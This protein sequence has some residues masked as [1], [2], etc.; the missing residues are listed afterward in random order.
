M[1]C[2]HNNYFQKKNQQTGTLTRVEYIQWIEK[3]LKQA[4]IVHDIKLQ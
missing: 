3:V 4:V 2:S 1:G